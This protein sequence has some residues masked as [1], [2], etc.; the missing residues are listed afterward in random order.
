MLTYVFPS[1]RSEGYLSFLF[2]VQFAEAYPRTKQQHGLPESAIQLLDKKDN[3]PAKLILT[4]PKDRKSLLQ[5]KR[6][7]SQTE[8][9]NMIKVT[10]QGR[11]SASESGDSKSHRFAACQR[12]AV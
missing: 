5:V 8:M 7:P 12:H 4:A 2:Q 9:S 6:F 3:A 1:Y 10:K 11:D